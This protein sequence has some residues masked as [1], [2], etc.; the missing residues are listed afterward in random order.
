MKRNKYSF[1]GSR[2][3]FTGAPAI[4]PGGYNLDK[5]NQSYEP[6]MVIPA[7]SLAIADESTRTVK[8]IKTAKVAAIDTEDTKKVSLRV[9]EFF[10][11]LFV[12]GE[13]V[14]KA[15]AISGQF[16]AAPTIVKV[17]R[18]PGS[19]V[20]ELSAAIEGLNAGD[21]LEQVVSG[22]A[23]AAAEI[24]KATRVTV[25][26]TVVDEYETAIDVCHDTMQYALFENRVAPIPDSQKDSVTGE[27]LAAN[28][29]VRLTK[30]LA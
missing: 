17:T 18:K 10:E 4:A 15:G 2:P 5:T 3:V 12:A 20:I 9:D 22:D 26:D 6:G 28:P 8:I 16:S 25:T 29:H 23:D 1:T 30:A 27:Y 21:V 11:P 13:S 24:G 14:L 19:F 7:G